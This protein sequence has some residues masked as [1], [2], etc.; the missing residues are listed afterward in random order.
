MGSLHLFPSPRNSPLITG[1]APPSCS[2]PHHSLRN[3]AH[4][5]PGI[6]RAVSR[7]IRGVGAEKGKRGAA[8]LFQRE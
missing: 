5:R 4:M 8:D 3:P 6:S 1:L 2:A 7:P